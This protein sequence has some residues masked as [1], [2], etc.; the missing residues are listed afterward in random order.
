MHISV[1][2]FG[3]S[4]ELLTIEIASDLTIRDLKAIIE[5]ESDFGLKADDM[6]LYS[7]GKLLRD[8]NQTLQQSNLKDY[9]VVT[10]QRKACK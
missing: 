8:E 5:A 7:D 1:A 9:D 4:E 6:N 3:G 10:C 2:K